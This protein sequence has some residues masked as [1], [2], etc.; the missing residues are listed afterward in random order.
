MVDTAKSERGVDYK[1]MR[2]YLDLLESHGLLHRIK[3][4]VDLKHEVGAITARS[5]ERGGPALLFENVKDYPG[6]PLVSNIMSSPEQVARP[7][8]RW[9]FYR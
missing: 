1:D 6:M 7:F 3:A 8:K 2:G 9:C 5:L 4:E